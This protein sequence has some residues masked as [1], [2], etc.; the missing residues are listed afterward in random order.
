M[1]VASFMKLAKIIISVVILLA[2][3]S[4]NLLAKQPLTANDL[5]TVAKSDTPE[6]EKLTAEIAKYPTFIF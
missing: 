6:I 3:Q 5:P 4:I 1:K 2:V